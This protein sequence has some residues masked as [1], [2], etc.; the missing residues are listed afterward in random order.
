[1]SDVTVL[2]VKHDEHYFWI[3]HYIRNGAPALPK[4][5]LQIWRLRLVLKLVVFAK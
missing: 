4:T 5:L 3:I 1:M 2:I